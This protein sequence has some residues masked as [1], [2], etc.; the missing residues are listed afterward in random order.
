[1]TLESFLALRVWLVGLESCWGFPVS[2]ACKTVPLGASK[3]NP[4]KAVRCTVEVHLSLGHQKAALESFWALLA[5][6]GSCLGGVW[7]CRMGCSDPRNPSLSSTQQL[8]TCRIASRHISNCIN[9]FSYIFHSLGRLVDIGGPAI[10][11]IQ[12]SAAWAVALQSGR[13]PRARVLA[14]GLR[15]VTEGYRG[16]P[17]LPPTWPFL[18]RSYPV[19]TPSPPRPHPVPTSAFSVTAMGESISKANIGE[20]RVNIVAR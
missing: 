8:N 17:P 14:G 10:V 16:V 12:G 6:L 4:S 5:G 9:I 18:P 2:D 13:R 19:V 7:L 15:L 3:A 11:E 1:M 20:H